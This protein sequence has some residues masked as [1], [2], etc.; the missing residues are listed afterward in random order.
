MADP[1]A[2]LLQMKAIQNRQK[3]QVD[4]LSSR[5]ARMDEMG[6]N[7]AVA[8][9]TPGMTAGATPYDM[10]A[11]QRDMNDD[12]ITGVQARA[13]ADYE[14]PFQTGIRDT[15]RTDAL[16]KLLMP[17]QA[18]GEY[19]LRGEQMRGDTSVKVA[20]INAEQRGQTALDARQALDFRAH[21][22][23]DAIAQRMSQSAHNASLEKQAT[24]AEKVPGGWRDMFS[25]QTSGQKKAADLR[26]QEN[27]GGQTPASSAADPQTTAQQLYQMNPNAPMDQIM[28]FLTSKGIDP[29][30]AQAIVLAYQQMQGG[31]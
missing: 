23:Q 6:H 15:A 27:Y 31:R 4:L 26:A 3:P 20:N 10:G 29:Q 28:P 17:I 16:N 13:E 7:L 22:S 5:Q 21:A 9:Q 11:L 14:S 25:S 30:S 18:R 19:D 8:K 24:A 1:L 2:A 12:P